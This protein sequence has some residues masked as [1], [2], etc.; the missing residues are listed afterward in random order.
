MIFANQHTYII[1]AY[2][3][4]EE[5]IKEKEGIIIFTGSP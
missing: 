1:F 3:A 5:E 4:L 2:A